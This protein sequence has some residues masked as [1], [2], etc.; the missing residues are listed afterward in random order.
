MISKTEVKKVFGDKVEFHGKA[1]NVALIERINEGYIC[2]FVGSLDVDKV[3]QSN[4]R[5]NTFYA[6]TEKEGKLI[7]KQLFPRNIIYETF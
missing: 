1:N 4:K 2:T 7:K 5:H 3:Y 6:V